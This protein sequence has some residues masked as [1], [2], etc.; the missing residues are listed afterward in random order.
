MATVRWVNVLL[1]LAIAAPPAAAAAPQVQLSPGPL[2]RAHAAIEGVTNC[3]QCHDPARAITPARCLTC[4]KRIAER[5]ARKVGVHRNVTDTCASCHKEHQGADADLRHLDRQTF[6]HAA[7]TGFPLDGLHARVGTTCSACHKT[8][9]FLTVRPAC[10]TCH[11]DPH[12]EALGQACTACH[13]PQLAFKRTRERFDHAR[14]RFALTGSHQRVACE[15]CH[16]DNLFRR[17]ERQAGSLSYE[18]NECSSCHQSPHRRPLGPSC[19]TCHSTERWVVGGFDHS[20][21]SFA[22]VGSHRTVACAGCHVSGVR[23]PLR[24]DRC[25][26]CHTN[27]HRESI[28]DDCR[29]CHTEETFRKARFDHRERTGFPLDATHAP[30]TCQK[31]HTTLPAETLPRTSRTVMDFS[32]LSRA[33]VSCHKDQHNGE[34]GLA[35]DACHRP[36]TF[37]VAGFSHPRIPEFFGGRHQGVTCV[38]CHVRSSGQPAAPAAAPLKAT[39]VSTPRG[40]TPP[41]SSACSTCHDDVHMGQVGALCE[42]CHTVE[43]ERFAPAK[44]A[45]DAAPFVLTGKHKTAPCAKCHPKE[46]GVFPAGAGTAARLQPV[47]S[48]CAACHT[49][50][51]LGQVDPGCSRCHTPD[52]FAVAS[53]PHAGLEYMFSIGNHGVLPCARCHKRETGQFPAGAGSTVRFKVARTCIGCHP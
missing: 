30:L 45:H 17:A 31:C 2:V 49:D 21:T 48:D 28:K 1:W 47:Q 53:F 7:E 9:S 3:S 16:K 22:L 19:T 6:D 26:A 46:T 32:G 20:K 8:R 23:T 33:C 38:K 27:V 35:C 44:F 29:A 42:R 24:S 15:K 34:F 50:P 39:A 14:A 4:H 40:G 25:S 37:K 36:A 43:A 52:G 10:Q 12:K 13:T 41:P 5:I 18:F 51:H 11:Q